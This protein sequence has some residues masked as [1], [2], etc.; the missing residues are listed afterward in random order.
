MAFITASDETIQNDYVLF[1]IN[2]IK[3]IKVGDL[4]LI[5]GLVERRMDKYQIVINTISKI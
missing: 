3:D 5:N 2:L 4:V 1:D